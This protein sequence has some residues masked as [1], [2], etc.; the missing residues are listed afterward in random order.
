M[1]GESDIVSL[2]SIS[3]SNSF[4]WNLVYL[5][6]RSYLV[7]KKLSQGKLSQVFQFCIYIFRG[8][9][10][11]DNCLLLIICIFIAI[12][13]IF[14]VWPTSGKRI[15]TIP[16]SMK[17]SFHNGFGNWNTS[18]SIFIPAHIWCK[19]ADHF[20]HI[21]NTSLS[22][23]SHFWSKIPQFCTSSFRSQPADNFSNTQ[24]IF[25]ISQQ[26]FFNFSILEAFSL[27]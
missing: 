17:H 8:M 16:K 10:R 12:I 19:I 3:E 2:F 9:Y 1:R 22:F 13:G 4:S 21:K 6:C 26:I 23:Q 25:N 14:I 27:V 20:S 18:L 7:W 15:P 24:M 5:F 11:Y